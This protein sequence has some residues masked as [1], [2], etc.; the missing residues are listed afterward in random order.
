MPVTPPKPKPKKTVVLPEKLVGPS[1]DIAF[2][3]RAPNPEVPGILNAAV[4]P[5]TLKDAFVR[6]VVPEPGSYRINCETTCPLSRSRSS[7]QDC[8]PIEGKTIV[9]PLKIAWKGIRSF[10][11]S[12]SMSQEHKL[13]EGKMIVGPLKSAL[14][15]TRSFSRS[16]SIHQEHRLIEGK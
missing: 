4:D 3:P 14:K 10:S 8:R 16:R 11:R 9:R 5:K 7:P 13:I 15:G 12:K 2:A 1:P 6:P